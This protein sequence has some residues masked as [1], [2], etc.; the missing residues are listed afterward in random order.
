[1]FLMR[2]STLLLIISPLVLA[3][4]NSN[5]P[6]NDNTASSSS[7]DAMTASS[8]SEEA[9]AM[10]VSSKEMSAMPVSSA[11]ASSVAA[12]VSSKA[13]VKPRP[14]NVSV[15]IK[16]FAFASANL[17][18]AKGTTVTWTNGD[19]APHTVTGDNGGPNSPSLGTGQSYSYTFNTIGTFPYHC[20]VHPM[21]T[22]TVTVTP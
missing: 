12:A 5:A 7:V 14:P 20:A 8:S 6:I 3:A 2:T 10:P 1:M 17:T 13:S 11:A 15:S 16:N 18:V 9:S 21:M 19:G 22:A 4:C